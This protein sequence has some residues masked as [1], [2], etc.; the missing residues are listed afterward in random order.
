MVKSLIAFW[1]QFEFSSVAIAPCSHGAFGSPR[2][3]PNAINPRSRIYN[4]VTKEMQKGK[5]WQIELQ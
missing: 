3:M 1:Q 4:I 5:K 2:S